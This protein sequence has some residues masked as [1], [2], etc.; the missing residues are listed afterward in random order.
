MAA[1]YYAK[2]EMEAF[3]QVV[4]KSIDGPVKRIVESEDRN[5]CRKRDNEAGGYF[6]N[7]QRSSSR[8]N[9]GGGSRPLELAPTGPKNKGKGKVTKWASPKSDKQAELDTSQVFNELTDKGDP[10]RVDLGPRLERSNGSGNKTNLKVLSNPYLGEKT[11]ASDR[12]KRRARDTS[13]VNQVQTKREPA[14]VGNEDN[15]RDTGKE[16]GSSRLG[17]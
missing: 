12:W 11:K 16:D 13:L 10:S 7:S 4:A 1:G 17:K 8:V 6:F 9:V 15:D 3:W 2:E 5:D 14:A